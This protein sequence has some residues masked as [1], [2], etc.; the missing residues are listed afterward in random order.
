MHLQHM[1]AVDRCKMQLNCSLM[2]KICYYVTPLDFTVKSVTLKNHGTISKQLH[3]PL[4]QG[5]H[6]DFLPLFCF[7]LF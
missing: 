5:T 1:T 7:P 4:G 6:A 3:L 2:I